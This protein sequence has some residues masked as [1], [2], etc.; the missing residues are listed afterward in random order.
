MKLLFQIDTTSV[1]QR[2]IYGK[3]LKKGEK[4]SN[5]QRHLRPHRIEH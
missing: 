2:Q 1:Y 4:S 5:H 3:G